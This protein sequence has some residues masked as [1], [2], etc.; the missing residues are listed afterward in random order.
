VTWTYSQTSG[1]T[2]RDTVY[3]ARGYSGYAPAGGKNN[4]AMQT[5]H[6][7]G[8]IPQGAWTI[9][10]MVDVHPRLGPFCLYL[11]P[12]EGTQ[13]YGRDQFFVH[14]DSIVSPG[15]ASHGCI[16][17]GRMYREAMWRSGDRDLEV[18]L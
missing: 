8:P 2:A 9:T 18:T 3:L 14:G 4:P 15:N 12:K 10:A 6:D 16:I 11:T 13:T 5:V 1:E 17:L 7:V